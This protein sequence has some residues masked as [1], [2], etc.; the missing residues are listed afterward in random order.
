MGGMSISPSQSNVIPS[1]PAPRPPQIQ[2]SYSHTLVDRGPPTPGTP[3]STI[4]SHSPS[5]APTQQQ[6]QKQQPQLPTSRPTPQLTPPTSSSSPNGTTPTA[7]PIA[8]AQKFT[9]QRAAPLNPSQRQEQIREAERRR[10]ERQEQQNKDL[11]PVSPSPPKTQVNTT[12][13][14]PSRLPIATSRTPAT[15]TTVAAAEPVKPVATKAKPRE[16]RIS[17]LTESQ[18]M[19][20]L[21]SVVSNGDPNS[22][23]TK[24]KKVGQ[25]A[26]GSVYVARYTSSIPLRTKMVNG[27]QITQGHKVAIKQMDLANQ[28]RKELI[29]NEILVMKESQ[30]PNIV[31]FL[32]SYLVRGN[33][34]WVVMEF[35]EGGALTDVIDHNT[36]SED[37]ISCISLEVT[38]SF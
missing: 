14:A 10:R 33:E 5:F 19:E 9:P 30:H 3:A 22:S 1:R 38:P 2:T 24:I 21:R 25:G 4:S 8:L 13:P 11:P 15:T 16:Q 6:L 28:P 7:T 29:V 26:S 35:M 37:Q 36:L 27:T 23:Y 20:K 12:T 32:D 34:L 31:N 17:A 18:I